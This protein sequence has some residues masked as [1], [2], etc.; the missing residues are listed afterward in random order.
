MTYMPNVVVAA[1]GNVIQFQF[2][3][4]NHTVTQSTEMQACTPVQA[5]AGQP[6]PVNSGHLPFTA[7]STTVSTFEMTVTNTQ[8]MF[9]Y[10]ATGPHCQLGQVMVINP[11]VAP[12]SVFVLIA[13]PRCTFVL[14]EQLP[15]GT[16]PAQP[17]SQH[18]P[19]VAMPRP[20]ASTVPRSPAGRWARFPWPRRPSTRRRKV[21]RE[22]R[23][24][25]QRLLKAELPLPRRGR[26]RARLVNGTL[27]WTS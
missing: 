15:W 1:P 11:Y 12:P 24:P 26:P 16:E 6:D 25:L 10:C 13:T 14:T 7:G 23:R 19:D 8:P 5:V 4:G 20:R 9:I 21:N 17:R 2:S 18:T 22:D 27:S 3:A